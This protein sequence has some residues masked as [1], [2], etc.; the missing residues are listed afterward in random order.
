MSADGLAVGLAFAAIAWTLLPLLRD[1]RWWVRVFDFPR[2]HMAVLTTCILLAYALVA[3]WSEPLDVVLLATLAGCVVFQLV[4]VAP[5][6]PIHRKQLRAAISPHEAD[7]LGLLVVN[8]LTPNRNAARLLEMVRDCDPDVV[9]AVETDG[10]W[11]TELAALEPEYIHTVKR[12]L[13]NLYGMHLY[14]RLELLDPQ[15]RYL[16]ED[17]VPSIHTEVVLRSGRRVALHCLHPA[18]PSPTHNPTS[19]ERDAELLVVAKGIDTRERS[20]VVMGDLNDVAWSPTTRLFREL[21]GLLDPRIGRGTYS[22]FHARFPLLRWP[23]DHV[24]CSGDFELVSLSRLGYFGSDHFPIH[25]VLSHAPSAETE[26]ERPVASEEQ[27]K[28]AEEKIE[29]A[30]ADEDALRSSGP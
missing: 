2:I 4:H 15:V 13:D 10:W 26:H 1:E 24:F 30:D 17:D 11:E 23:L 16:V 28:R 22:T 18:P 6:T 20:V 19:I 27:R 3:G 5:Y 8:V 21:S 29:K 25:A 7:L 14:S 12:P 9:L